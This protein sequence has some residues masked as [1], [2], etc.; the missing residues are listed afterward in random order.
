MANPIKAV[1]TALRRWFGDD[2]EQEARRLAEEQLRFSE[3]RLRLATETGKVGIWDWDVAANRVTWTGAL[4]AIHGIRPG[5]FGGRSEDL[6]A[7]TYPEDR[8]AVRRDIRTALREGHAYE[9][10]FRALRPNGEVIWIYV[11]ARIVRKGGRAVRVVGATIDIDT[12]K[13]VELAF[14]D[15]ERRLSLALRA[16]NAGVWE[17]NPITGE[18]F[19]SKELRELY[20]YD[21]STPPTREHWVARLHP[22]DREPV[23]THLTS[24]LTPGNSEFRH[25]FRLIHPSRGVLWI[26][27]AGNVERDASGRIGWMRGISIDITRMKQVEEELREADQRKNEFLATLAHEL[28]NPLAPIRNGLE[29]LRLAQSGDIADRARN[30][31]DRQLQQMVHLI[32]DLLE[33]SRITRGKIQLNRGP[34]DLHA[35]LQSAVE[36]SKPL[37]DAAGHELSIDMPADPLIVDGDLI[38]LA[39]VFGNL[40]NNA[41]KYTNPGG[42]ICLSAIAAGDQV[43][44]VVRDN[45]IGIAPA[46]LPKVFEMFA[47]A[48]QSSHRTQGG[49]GIGLSIAKR[50]VE[51]HGGVLEARSEGP[52][53]GSEFTVRL[54]LRIAPVADQS[55]STSHEAPSSPTH[56]LRVLVADDNTDAAASLSTILKMSGHDVR[57]AYDGE[58]ALHIAAAFHPNVALLDIGMPHL[59]GY[60]VCRQLRRQAFGR[61]M[62]IIALTGWGQAEDKQRSREAG[63]DQHLVKPADIRAVEQ[64]LGQADRQPPQHPPAM[65][66]AD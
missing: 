55:L 60:E 64:L 42:Q 11:N 4:Y 16:A 7:L 1:G 21:E 62:L 29:I 25:D 52:G 65:K 13:R 12:R 41:A 51:M 15:S 24:A 57:T 47:Q 20:G 2:G 44:V 18:S 56:A 31:M 63:F 50:L 10:E 43:S 40:L 54:P 61:D 45:G 46:M 35:A 59:D 17:I 39:Q 23:R 8:E 28:R 9:A 38:R 36:M 26:H 49:L 58:E 5:E 66:E 6:V 30:M 37:M 33:V 34:I 27:A 48:D 19:W 32:D 22:D 14:R 53:M 3:E